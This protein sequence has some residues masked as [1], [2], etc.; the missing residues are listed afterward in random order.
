MKLVSWNC[1]G[2]GGNQKIK[3]VKRIKSMEANSILLIQ[4]T[5][6][7]AKDSLSTMK[8]VW[9]KGKGKAVSATGLLGGILT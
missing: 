4:E 8:K 7:T 1:Q 5:K 3:V 6:K 2:L 9:P